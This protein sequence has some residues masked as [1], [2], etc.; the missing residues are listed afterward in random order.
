MPKIRVSRRVRELLVEL[1]QAYER[2]GAQVEILADR[3]S[4]PSLAMNAGAE[5]ESIKAQILGIAW[6]INRAS[7]GEN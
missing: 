1:D 7:R 3:R 5:R 2:Y 6:R 4:S